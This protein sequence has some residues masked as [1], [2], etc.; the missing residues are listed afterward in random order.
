MNYSDRQ[1]MPEEKP[2]SH[3][4]PRAVGALVVGALIALIA[5]RRGFRG[6]NVRGLLK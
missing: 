1:A 3:G 4:A 5:I 2:T 6:I